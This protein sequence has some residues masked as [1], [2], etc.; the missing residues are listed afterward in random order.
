MG[1]KSTPLQET[2]ISFHRTLKLPRVGQIGFVVHDVDRAMEYYRDTFGIRPWLVS[3]PERSTCVVRGREIRAR[4][5]IALAYSGRI[6]L[7]LIEVLEGETVHTEALREHG[8]GLHHLGFIVNDFTERLRA[9]QAAGIEVL[10][11]GG[12][13]EMGFR[14]DYAYLDTVATGG[15]I[16]EL[17]QNRVG[18]LNVGMSP[19]L[20]RLALLLQKRGGQALRANDSTAREVM[21]IHP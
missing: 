8:E 7:E 4:L 2:D 10:Q 15:V 11:Q 13:E 9:C 21:P 20:L 14:I 5:K 19:L 16:F 1:L 12:I 18:N 17:I 3:I 6:Q